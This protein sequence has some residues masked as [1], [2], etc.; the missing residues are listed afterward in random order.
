L[1]KILVKFSLT[2]SSPTSRT[3]A[4][5]DLKAAKEAEIK[6]GQDQIDTKTNELADTDEKVAN[7]K[8]DIE[9]TRRLRV[10]ILVRV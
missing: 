8:Q 2:F 9:D 5:E 10:T 4:F 1:S 3:Q 7:D 6:A